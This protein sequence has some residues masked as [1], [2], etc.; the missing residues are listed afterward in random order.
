MLAGRGDAE[1]RAALSD[2]GLLLAT[3]SASGAIRLW[4]LDD[5]AAVP[6][7]LIAQAAPAS[8]LAFSDAATLVSAADDGV[9]LWH[10][11]PTRRCDAP[12]GE[13]AARRARFGVSSSRRAAGAR[14]KP[15]A[16]RA[17]LGAAAMRRATGVLP[18]QRARPSRTS[19]PDMS[20]D[21]RSR[22]RGARRR[23]R[24]ASGTGRA[25][26][27]GRSSASTPPTSILP[28]HLARFSP[29]GRWL[30]TAS[31]D[32]ALRLWDLDAL[33]RT[34]PSRR[35]SAADTAARSSTS[36]SAATG[37][38]CCRRRRTDRCGCGGATRG[39]L[40]AVGQQQ[41][42]A[43]VNHVLFG[44]GDAWAAA[45]ADDAS[46]RLW[47]APFDAGLSPLATL[48]FDWPVSWCRSGGNRFVCRS[49]DAVHVWDGDP[50]SAQRLR[51][52]HATARA[53]RR[54]RVATD[55]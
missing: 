35:Q 10:L 8:H 31:R 30:A 7:T 28:I 44:P 38:G 39:E 33:N 5:D 50:L 6:R 47:R 36:R 23:A 25:T 42:G 17:A 27:S 18:R 2:D 14:G 26:P 45:C 13:V 41:L 19:P 11:P 12:I 29:D 51:L 40:V 32:D 22:R 52:P 16:G 48:W 1:T 9:R 24:S 54:H 15:E 53:D 49:A 20:R 55:A 46:V 21:G 43:P 4:N 37:S 34:K 3:T